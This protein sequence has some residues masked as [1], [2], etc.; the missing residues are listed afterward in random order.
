VDG[1]GKFHVD[2]LAAGWL[3]VP[4]F[5]PA[6]QPLRADV[7]GQIE[8]KANEEL[9][10]ENPG[11]SRCQN[12]WAGPEVRHSGGRSRLFCQRD[13]RPGGEQ[14]FN[15]GFAWLKYEVETDG[16]G[17]FECLVPPGP[18]NVNTSGYVDGYS[19]AHSWLPKEKRGHW[20]GMRFVVPA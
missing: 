8:V 6:D 5:L 9:A 2:K 12:P 7:A 13:L 17:R 4:A 1:D 20:G 15:P 18:I 10:A 16:N 19:S 11:G 3:F 14:S